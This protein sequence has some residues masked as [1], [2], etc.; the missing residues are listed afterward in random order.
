MRLCEVDGEE[1]GCA[2]GDDK[3][4][5]FDDCKK[6]ELPRG[7]KLGVHDVMEASGLPKSELL[8]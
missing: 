6:P 2:P 8:L 7:N 3:A 1:A 4:G 5:K